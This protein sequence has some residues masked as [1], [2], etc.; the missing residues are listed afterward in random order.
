MAAMIWMW[1]HLAGEPIT[2]VI[3]IDGLF[4]L[5]CYSLYI[6]SIVWYS[7][8]KLLAW[9]K[10]RPLSWSLRILDCSWLVFSCTRN[11]FIVHYMNG[12]NSIKAALILFTHNHSTL[13]NVGGAACNE[14]PT[15]NHMQIDLLSYF[16]AFQLMV[17]W[18]HCFSSVSVL[19]AALFSRAAGGF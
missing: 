13:C 16:R 18:F 12:Y 14:E 19:P 5:T 11:G 2:G 3:N 8:G 4:D 17:S 6:C 7:F 15:E 1:M 10:G 9:N